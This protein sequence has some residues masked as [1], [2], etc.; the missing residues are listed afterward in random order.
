MSA[1]VIARF[2]SRDAGFADR[3]AVLAG[4]EASRS[5]NAVRASKY[6]YG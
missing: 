2:D 3:L 5:P 6:T 4:Y 1:P